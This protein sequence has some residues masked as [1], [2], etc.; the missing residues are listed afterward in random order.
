[1]NKSIDHLHSLLPVGIRSRQ[2]QGVNKLNIHCLETDNAHTN[3]PL[4]ILLHGF[5]EL[6]F[7]WRKIMLPLSKAGYYVVAPDQ[8]GFGRTSGWDAN[9]DSKLEPFRMLNLVRDVIGLMKGIGHSKAAGIIGHN[10]GAAVAGWCS[11]LHPDIFQSTA[12][13][14]APFTGM[15]TTANSS[16]T[17]IRKLDAKL[18]LQ[19]PPRKHYQQYY[20][21]RSANND[22]LMCKQGVHNFL[23]AYFHYKSA[24]WAGNSPHPLASWN[25]TELSLLP[26]Y[27]I[28]HKSDSMPQT[29]AKHMP[30]SEQI[31]SCKWL[32][33]KELSFYSSEYSTTGFQ[34]GLNWY[35]CGTSNIGKKE[36][37]VFHGKSIEIP[38]CFIA[39]SKDWGVFQRP[40]AYETMQNKTFKNM[41]ECHLIPKAGHWVQQEQPEKVSNI[42]IKFLS[43]NHKKSRT[44]K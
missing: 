18:A 10:S 27:Y 17:R 6:S 38:A 24:D 23:R 7:S 16:S 29:V 21:T 14:S 36:M 34:G 33:E 2:V 11:L 39:G 31:S 8:R 37:E 30:T 28:M 9:F 40:G 42:L 4:L 25:A 32:T 20:S 35:R 44:K 5:P 15:Q 22:M 12:I 13:M 19:D 3:K 1:M 43:K 26:T 41:K